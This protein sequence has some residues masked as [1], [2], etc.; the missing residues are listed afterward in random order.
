MSAIEW[1]WQWIGGWDAAVWLGFALLSCAAAWGAVMVAGPRWVNRRGV[2]PPTRV[3]PR[4]ALGGAPPKLTVIVAARD[5]E[6]AIGARIDNLLAQKDPG[7][8]IEVL[9]V[10][11]GCTD[12]TAAIARAKMS[13]APAGF[14]VNVLELLV[15]RG[16]EEAVGVGADHA[17]GDIIALTDA[18]THWNEDVAALLVQ[19]LLQ[20]GIGA[21]SGR[22]LYRKRDGGVAAGFSVYQ[23]MVVAQRQGGASRGLQTST[24]GACSAAWARLFRRYIGYMNSDLQLL[25]LA[26]EDGLGTLYINDAI[27]WEEPRTSLQEELKARKR[28]AR[29]CLVSLVPLFGRLFAA[30]A[31]WLI[32]QFLVTKMTRWFIW[33]PAVL[34]CT[35]LLLIALNAAGWLATAA[36]LGLAGAGLGAMVG[37]ARLRGKLPGLGRLGAAA[38]YVMLAVE[39]TSAALFQVL[40]GQTSLAW[41][42]DR[43]TVATEAPTSQNPT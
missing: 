39:A 1:L 14:E 7:G 30:R 11:D 4:L 37:T 12:R 22:V 36:W 9:V 26:V 43:A 19:G 33:L 5:E 13:S 42:P 41:Q 8:G 35:G 16:K 15:N 32:A 29:L 25:L 28:I 17:R 23:K 3:D 21:V 20:D 2:L 31:W 6:A 18:T 24:S 27:A 38:G 34:A 10:C 40:R